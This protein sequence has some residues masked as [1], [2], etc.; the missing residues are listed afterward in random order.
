MEINKLTNHAIPQRLQQIPSPPKKLYT[1]GE[2]IS[3]LLRRPT[4]AIV[5]SRKVSPYGRQ[6]TSK[7]AGK[8]A[9]Q[10]IVIISGLALG[11][12]AIAHQ[13]AL[14]AGGFTIAVLP[15]PIEKIYPGSHRGLAEQIVRRGGTLISE[16][17]LGAQAFNF[18]TNFIARNRLVSGLADA[19]LITEAAEKSGSLHTAH[20]ALEQGK[21]VLAVP[22]NITSATSVGTNN[23]LKAGAMPATT[24]EDVLHV[25]Q[26]QQKTILPLK[27]AIGK[28]A[29]E[30]V[31]IDLLMT[32]VSD[33]EELQR[34]S[35]LDIAQFN[36][37]L[38]MLEITGK[39]RSLGANQW[40]LA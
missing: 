3:V 20:F 16:Y 28:N 1:C 39:V 12:D 24:Y 29:E 9:Q 27:I 19:L 14:D 10:G 31:V 35:Q 22:G 11:V 36:Q 33:G 6:V 32:G 21:D 7:L 5:G 40:A 17:T 30:Q 15:G 18:K 34:A 4:V 26:L 25:L 2:D 8:L 37:T 38:T 13:A 23:L